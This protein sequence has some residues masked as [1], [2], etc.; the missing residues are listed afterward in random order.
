MLVG[1][2]GGSVDIRIPERE[3][4]ATTTPTPTVAPQIILVSGPGS[5]TVVD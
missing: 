2:D 4:G 1:G 5:S 3:E